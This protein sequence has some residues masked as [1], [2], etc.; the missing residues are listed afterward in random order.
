MGLPL[1]TSTRD[2]NFSSSISSVIKSNADP[3]FLNTT[4]AAHFLKLIFRL[5]FIKSCVD[6]FRPNSWAETSSTR[7]TRHGCD[8]STTG[9]A[10]RAQQGPTSH[11]LEE[12]RP[13][14]GRHL[15]PPVSHPCRGLAVRVPTVILRGESDPPKAPIHH[16]LL[17]LS[18]LLTSPQG[19]FIPHSVLRGRA[20]H[21]LVLGPRVSSVRP[22]TSHPAA[23]WVHST[24]PSTQQ[25]CRKACWTTGSHSPPK[26]GAWHPGWQD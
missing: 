17:R 7:G 25:V 10:K 2:S 9:K 11:L 21:L 22:L 18:P 13:S 20:C 19:P 16:T 24:T 15:G 8:D 4:N 23:S 6:P 14:A 26:H 1:L 5:Y 12:A 3:I